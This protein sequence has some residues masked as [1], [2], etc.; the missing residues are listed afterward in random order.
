MRGEGKRGERERDREGKRDRREEK[1][2][3]R[4][5]GGKLPYVCLQ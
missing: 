5:G 4:R 3:K 1:R 2:K